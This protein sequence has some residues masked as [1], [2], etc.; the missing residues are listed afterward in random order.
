V[1]EPLIC[2]DVGSMPIPLP[3]IQIWLIW[4][5]AMIAGHVGECRICG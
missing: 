2:A 3:A 5:A 4:H 1:H